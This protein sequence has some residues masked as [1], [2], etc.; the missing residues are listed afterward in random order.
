MK[1]SRVTKNT[2][3]MK[4][5]PNIIH[6]GAPVRQVGGGNYTVGHETVVHTSTSG[7]SAYETGLQ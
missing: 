1:Y 3:Y 5:R 7:R 4:Y 2:V 6:D